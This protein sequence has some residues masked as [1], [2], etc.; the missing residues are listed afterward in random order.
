MKRTASNIDGFITPS[1]TRQRVTLDTV[2][3]KKSQVRD[4]LLPPPNRKTSSNLGE[5]VRSALAT[6]N[7]DDWSNDLD[8]TLADLPG[9]NSV[10]P[11]GFVD[12]KKADKR[13]MKKALRHAPK[14]KTS[15]KKKIIIG[16][17][18]GVVFLA[19]ALFTAMKLL[20]PQESFLGNWW[21]VLTS[22]PLKQDANGRTNILLFGTAPVDYDGPLL[23][24]TV[25]VVSVNQTDKSAYMVSLPRDLWVK[26]YCPNYAL[27][28]NAGRLNE[29]YRCALE[30]DD[31][32]NEAAAAAEFQDKVGEILGLDVQYYAHLS[33]NGVIDMVN[34][35]GGIDLKIESNNP[36][37]LYDVA[38]GI[39]FE[40]GETVHMDGHLALAFIRARGSAGGYGFEDSNFARERNQQLVIQA[41]QKK[42]LSAGTLSN[43]VAVVSSAQALGENL[44]TNFKVGEI[45]TLARLLGEVDTNNLVSLPLIDDAKGI[46]LVTNENING[47]SVVVPTAGTFDYSEIKQY[48]RGSMSSDPVV[49]EK[50][51]IDVLNGSEI[52]GRASAEADKLEKEGFATGY[53]GNADRENYGAVVVYQLSNDKPATAEA[54]KKLYGDSVVVSDF[55]FPY[56]TDA[57]FV[58]IVG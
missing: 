35:V 45:R 50:A 15:K 52:D 10:D 8:S 16:V 47:A 30:D 20:W 58:V 33:W 37:G 27:G 18:L 26:H 39:D 46:Y 41:L 29:T 2:P 48:I 24:D 34:A 56:T 13:L 3:A 12:N 51:V 28:T 14:P 36:D 40:N 4:G 5:S 42:A 11:D 22:E 49:R 25:M 54:L 23:S 57:D 7:Q 9:Y 19:A 21:D 55:P 53:I 38:T 17:I 32:A 43:P 44:R 1:A 31:E 6:S